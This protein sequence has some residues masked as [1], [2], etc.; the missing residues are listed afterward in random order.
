MYRKTLLTLSLALG[1]AAACAAQTLTVDHGPYLQD[2]GPRSATFVFHTSRRALALVDVRPAGTDS[3]RTYAQ[4]AYGLKAADT[5]FFAVRAAALRPG[6][7]Y[8]YRI[9]AKEIAGFQPY[10]V[11]FGD[12]TSTAWTPFRTAD[13]HRQGGSLF[14]VSDMHSRPGQL[15]KLLRLCD[16]A[17]CTDFVYAGDMMNYMERGGEEPFSS[18]IDKSVQLFASSKPF[19]YVRGNHET[20]GDLARTLPAYFPSRSGRLYGMRRLGD[21]ALVYLDSGEDKADTHPVYAGLTDF[22]AYRSEQARWLRRVVRSK[23]FREA[24]YRIV[25]C[26]FPLVMDGR[27]REEGTWAGWQDAI[28]KFLPALR[29]Q[30]V[31]LLVS[32]HTHHFAH[33]PAGSSEADFPILVQGSHCAARIDCANGR[34]RYRVADVSGK[35]LIDTTAVCR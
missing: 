3:V 12:S 24:R 4:S 17:T 8:E 1:L 29:G 27:S 14:V 16:Y 32:G 26:H 15:E 20:R 33:Y 6:T 23:A 28:D 34:L 9:R 5:T 13:P 30:G 19:I 10:K 7:A 18:F 2:V 21:I 35:T 25:V 31:D 22:D 11:T